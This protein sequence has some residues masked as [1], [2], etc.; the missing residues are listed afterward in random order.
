MRMVDRKREGNGNSSLEEIPVS[1]VNHIFGIILSAG[2]LNS[3]LF[4]YNN[5]A[6]FGCF[7]AH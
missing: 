2:S 3:L 5:L 4:L 7:V 6:R 1:R